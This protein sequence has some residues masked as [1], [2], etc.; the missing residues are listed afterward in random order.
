MVE[1]AKEN[2]TKHAERIEKRAWRVEEL[3][4]KG[5]IKEDSYGVSFWGF[6]TASK[7]VQEKALQDAFGDKKDEKGNALLLPQYWRDD[8]QGIKSWTQKIQKKHLDKHGDQ[9]GDWTLWSI[10]QL[11]KMRE[12]IRQHFDDV[13]TEE[14]ELYILQLINPDLFEVMW[15]KDTT[16]DYRHCLILGRDVHDRCVRESIGPDDKCGLFLV[17]NLTPALSS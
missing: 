6:T 16:W 4:S 2:D 1:Y 5:D 12:W 8:H 10:E 9:F 13:K 14:D 11:N 17:K 3:I 7:A 15:M